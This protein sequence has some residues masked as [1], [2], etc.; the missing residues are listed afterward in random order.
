MPDDSASWV[1]SDDDPD[2]LAQ[3]SE[4]WCDANHPSETALNW[5]ANV[6]FSLEPGQMT[7]L[8]TKNA[9]DVQLRD[10]LRARVYDH[11]LDWA[12]DLHWRMTGPYV[13]EFGK[14][15]SYG[16]HPAVRVYYSPE[17]LVWMCSE[18]KSDLPNGAII[19]K[20]M[21]NINDQ[22]GVVKPNNCMSIPDDP[23]REP[24]SWTAMY[25]TEVTYDRWY[26]AN[27]TMSVDGNPTVSDRSAFTVTSDV[28]TAQVTRNPNW[29]PT[30]YVFSDKRKKTL[31][32][33]PTVCMVPPVSTAMPQPF[34]I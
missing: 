26:W 10:F 4:A 32:S 11:K 24:G 15:E 31:W 5:R 30:G 18:R 20:E 2:E 22:L 25:R 33:N 17:M 27:P 7:D 34:P 3:K 9:F 29:Y 21:A 13:G 14:G 6:G 12:H 19:I 1:C 23:K 8:P 16:V 28:P